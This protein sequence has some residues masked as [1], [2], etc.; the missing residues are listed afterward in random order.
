[1]TLPSSHYTTESFRKKSTPKNA[2]IEFID[3]EDTPLL[4]SNND[5]N[6]PN[7][8]YQS[9]QSDS[10]EKNSA[11]KSY[12]TD[13]PR[14]HKP[15]QN[16]TSSRRSSL[17]KIESDFNPFEK[18][19][20]TP[21]HASDSSSKKRRASTP[22]L[23]LL[24]GQRFEQRRSSTPKLDPMF[25]QRF[26][27]QVD[28]PTVKNRQSFSIFSDNLSTVKFE[29]EDMSTVSG[30]IFEQAIQKCDENI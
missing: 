22:K 20:S 14:S 5:L 25:G 10:L 9:Y 28:M 12:K 18:S 24:F 16:I 15:S 21:K 17:N 30:D 3:E 2:H 1:M 6:F 27:H 8:N 7:H 13:S 26:E 19:L 23:D 11:R 4:P 29:Y